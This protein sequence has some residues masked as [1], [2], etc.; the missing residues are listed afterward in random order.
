MDN[1][2]HRTLGVLSY[3]SGWCRGR[4]AW[5]AQPYLTERL[6]LTLRTVFSEFRLDR[7]FISWIDPNG[8]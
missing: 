7:Q 1:D 3:A 4:K 8:N 6:R 2:K 5:G